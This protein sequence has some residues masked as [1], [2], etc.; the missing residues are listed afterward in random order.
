MNSILRVCDNR[1]VR[2]QMYQAGNSSPEG[3]RLVLSKLL[4]SRNNAAEILG[5]SSHADFITA[6]MLSKTPNGAKVFLKDLSA[7]VR[8]IAG[9]EFKMLEKLQKQIA[10]GGAQGSV[11]GLGYSTL[12]AANPGKG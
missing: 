4:K 5:F 2:Q 8:D 1:E 6:S 12:D 3:N 9:E 11:R 10:N 7:Q